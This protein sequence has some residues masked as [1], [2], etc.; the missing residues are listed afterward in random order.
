MGAG[1]ANVKMPKIRD[2]DK[3]FAGQRHRSVAGL[4]QGAWGHGAYGVVLRLGGDKFHGDIGPEGV[5]GGAGTKLDPFVRA[6]G[7]WVPDPGAV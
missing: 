5:R 1:E 7:R 3:S 2:A 6:A 4:A